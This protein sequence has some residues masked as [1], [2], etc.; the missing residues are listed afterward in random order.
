MPMTLSTG[1]VW[2]IIVGD[3]NQKP[4]LAAG[5]RSKSVQADAYIDTIYHNWMKIQ[6]IGDNGKMRA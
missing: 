6:L 3:K 1:L 4:H 5:L 2:S